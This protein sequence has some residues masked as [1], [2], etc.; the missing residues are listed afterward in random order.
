MRTLLLTICFLFC[1]SISFA[2]QK[3]KVV[4]DYDADALKAEQWAAYH[5]KH[6][7]KR[8]QEYKQKA[9]DANQSLSDKDK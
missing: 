9:L 5:Q 7:G 8:V 3:V 1:C 4:R 6:D 2:A